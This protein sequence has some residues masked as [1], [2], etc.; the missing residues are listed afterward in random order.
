MHLYINIIQ[1]PKD[2]FIEKLCFLDFTNLAMNLTSLQL[3]QRCNNHLSLQ[4]QYVI[5]TKIHTIHSTTYHYSPPRRTGASDKI[6]SFDRA[7]PRVRRNACTTR[8]TIRRARTR[9]F[10]HSRPA[11]YGRPAPRARTGP[12]PVSFPFFVRPA[13]LSPRRC[14]T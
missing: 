14:S 4:T 7:F 12:C 9:A 6:K 13:P 5:P 11:R 3:S 10:R 8:H 1:K 2:K